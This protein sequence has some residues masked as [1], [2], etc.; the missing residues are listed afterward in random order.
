G[1]NGLTR[2]LPA[3]SA[4]TTNPVAAQNRNRQTAPPPKPVALIKE[5]AP[6]KEIAPAP[7]VKDAA[8]RPATPEERQAVLSDPAVRRVFDTLDAR[9]V[10][11]RMPNAE[12]APATEKESK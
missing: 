7:T 12:Q 5:V 10:E 2:E 1:T 9:L 8:R 6:V 4:S 11:L 3:A